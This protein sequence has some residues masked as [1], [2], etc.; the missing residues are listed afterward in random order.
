ME[1]D[2]LERSKIHYTHKHLSPEMFGGNF[3]DANRDLELEMANDSK[4]ACRVIE[5][6]WD[7]YFKN[8]PLYS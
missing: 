1:N 7:D 8:R 5:E 2:I 3:C 4:L 6:Y